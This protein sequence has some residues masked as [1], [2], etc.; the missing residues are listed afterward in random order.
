VPTAKTIKRNP[1]NVLRVYKEI[2][3]YCKEYGGKKTPENND[4]EKIEFHQR[5]GIKKKK[6]RPQKREMQL[7]KWCLKYIVKQHPNLSKEE[8]HDVMKGI[9]DEVYSGSNSIVLHYQELIRNQILYT[10]GARVMERRCIWQK[11]SRCT[12]SF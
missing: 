1:M 4:L 5:Q 2:L 3:G 11:Y 7:F 9:Y 10:Q 12:R 8:V 6:R